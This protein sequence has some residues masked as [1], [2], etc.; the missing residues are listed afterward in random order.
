MKLTKKTYKIGGG[1]MVSVAL[2]SG[3][4]ISDIF[5]SRT[6][7]AQQ[8]GDNQNFHIAYLLRP[9]DADLLVRI[10]HYYLQENQNLVRAERAYRRALDQNP[11]IP[12]AHHQLARIY[13]I[14]ADFTRARRE[15]NAELAL[16]PNNFR[17]LYVRALNEAYSGNKPGAENDFRRVTEL[18]PLEWGSYNDLSWVLAEQGQFAEAATVAR[19]GI[20]TATGGAK[21]LWLW[22]ALGV[23]LFNAKIYAEAG[24][25]FRNAL[26]YAE[27]LDE[28][29]WHRAYSANTMRSA[30]SGLTAFK[31]ALQKNIEAVDDQ[32]TKEA[33]E[34]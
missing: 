26:R 15:I 21:N 19:S 30:A 29:E 9:N 28:Q 22:N 31:H 13:F 5:A 11:S 1:V 7:L 3:V 12:F 32:L 6:K 4:F 2:V 33:K 16:D 24:E 23:A 17:A 10:G 14:Q 20:E 25:A 27:D 34:R 8:A 18:A